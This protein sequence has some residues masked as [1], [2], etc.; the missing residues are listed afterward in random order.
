V[1]LDEMPAWSMFGP[2]GWLVERLLDQIARLDEATVARF[3]SPPP[4]IIEERLM[5]YNWFVAAGAVGPVTAAV[6]VSQAV[7]AAARRSDPATFELRPIT[8]EFGTRP[9]EVLMEPH[10]LAVLQLADRAAYGLAGRALIDAERFHAL[11]DRW[12]AVAGS[13]IDERDLRVARSATNRASSV[14]RRARRGRRQSH[15]P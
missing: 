3:Q 5:I 9:A 10:W 8:D 14:S 2:D 11:V 7:L 15:S 1:V 12:V 4:E 6:V 13:P